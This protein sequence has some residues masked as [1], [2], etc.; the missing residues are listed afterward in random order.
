MAKSNDGGERVIA[1]RYRLRS[2][3]GVGGM[4]VVWL[5][6]DPH[7]AREVAV[8]EVLLPAGLTE[9]QREEA[10]ARVRREARSAARI[11]HPSVVT[12]H[13]VLDVEGHPWVVMELIRGR[14]LQEELSAGGPIAPQR[15]AAIARELLEAVRAAHAAGVIHRD[16]KPANVMLTEGDRV[17][18]T[19]FGIATVEGGSSITRTGTLVGSPEYMPPERIRGDQAAGAADLWSVGVTLYAMCE[20][21]SPFRRDSV[22]AAIAAVLSAPLPPTERAAPLAPLIRGLLERDPARRLTADQAL[23]LLG[24]AGS[25]AGG[26]PVAEP[27]QQPQSQ[28]PAATYPQG[29]TTPSPSGPVT[30]PPNGPVTPRP[31]GPITPRPNGPVTPHPADPSTPNPAGGPHAGPPTGPMRSAPTGAWPTP[32]AEFTAQAQRTN[33]PRGFGIGTVLLGGGAIAVVLAVLLVVM[34]VMYAQNGPLSDARTYTNQW[35]AIDYPSDWEGRTDSANERFVEFTHPDGDAW[36]FVD[37]WSVEEGDPE[38]AHDWLVFFEEEGEVP[39]SYET[40]DVVESAPG[41]PASW[42][43][44]YAEGDYVDGDQTTPGRRLVAHVI[45]SDREGYVLAWNVPAHEATDYQGLHRSILDSF[46]PRS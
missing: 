3:L 34:F 46:E 37:S 27:A 18:L 15:A 24:E 28:P 22:T 4:G 30:P 38:T 6:W 36:F 43:V 41:F 40:I 26:A 9:S 21:A 14:S 12:I 25:P 5:A 45:V 35:Y 16:I 17:T 7:L 39:E 10:H 44:A 13:D 8:K 19:D 23:A 42:D 11:T 32:Y 31:S 33:P 20:G 2:K 1:A 29:P